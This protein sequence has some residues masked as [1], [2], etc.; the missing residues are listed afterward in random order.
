MVVTVV[1]MVV[2]M[3]T[4]EP[5]ADEDLSQVNG[6]SSGLSMLGSRPCAS[7]PCQNGGYCERDADNDLTTFTCRCPN[8]CI[9]GPLCEEVGNCTWL[10]LLL[11]PP[12]RAH[13]A[14]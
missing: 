9:T 5:I 6:D 14:N 13:P 12:L 10:H 3:F 4:F 1:A 11:S 2:S 7:S 8:S